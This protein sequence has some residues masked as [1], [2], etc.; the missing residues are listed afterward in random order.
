VFDESDVQLIGT[1]V[2]LEISAKETVIGICKD[3]RKRGVCTY[4]NRRLPRK[5]KQETETGRKSQG[6]ACIIA[7]MQF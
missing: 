5:Q 7:K 4:I 6:I 1:H 3:Y 2:I